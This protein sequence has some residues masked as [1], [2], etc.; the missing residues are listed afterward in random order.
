M[1][2]H[3]FFNLVLLGFLKPLHAYN[4]EHLDKLRHQIKAGKKVICNNYDLQDA[5]LSGLDLSEGDFTGANIKRAN[6]ARSKLHKAKLIGA[7]VQKANFYYADL[8]EADLTQANANGARFKG[9]QLLGLQYLNV[10]SAKGTLLT[11]KKGLA[12]ILEQEKE[13]DQIKR[14]FLS[15]NKKKFPILEAKLTLQNS[16]LPLH[17]KPHEE[18]S[19]EKEISSLTKIHASLHTKLAESV[20]KKEKYFI[21]DFRGLFDSSDYRNLTGTTAASYLFHECS[22]FVRAP[23]FKPFVK[24]VTSI[25]DNQ[26]LLIFLNISEIKDKRR[27]ETE[28]DSDKQKLDLHG[29]TPIKTKYKQI[30]KFIRNAFMLNLTTIEIITGR[31]LHNPDGEMG[32]LWRLCKAYLLSNKFRDYIQGIHS[33]SKDGG[34]KVILK[35]SW[36]KKNFKKPSKK[37]NFS[38]HD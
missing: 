36:E 23:F 34:W 35:N 24:N 33:I 6:L 14:E 37:Q 28:Y 11:D 38:I 2:K 20:K 31:G 30:D 4:K 25:C 27:V 12:K 13:T 1:V 15:K 19:K 18:K 32:T 5:D 16:Q 29:K 3:I 26:S 7:Q 22:A 10:S 8:T 9:A 21:V 17:K